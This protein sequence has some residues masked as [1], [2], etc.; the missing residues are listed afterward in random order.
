MAVGMRSTGTEAQPL[1]QV[2]YPAELASIRMLD[3]R[4]FDTGWVQQTIASGFESATFI[5][6]RRVGPIVYINGLIQTKNNLDHGAN[7]AVCTL[8]PQFRPP[9][10]VRFPVGATY[11]YWVA[12]ISTAG[13]IKC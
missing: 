5:K 11:T 2:A 13:V 12:D 1:F 10:I 8:D 7:I 3:G 4:I 6:A 9:D